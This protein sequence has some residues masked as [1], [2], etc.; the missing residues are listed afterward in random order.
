MITAVASIIGSAGSVAARLKSRASYEADRAATYDVWYQEALQGN[1]HSLDLL[2]ASAGLRGG[3]GIAPSTGSKDYAKNKLRALLDAGAITGPN[4]LPDGTPYVQYT[5]TNKAN[6]NA[7]SQP[8]NGPTQKPA[9][10]SINWLVV[11]V[12]VVGGFFAV[13]M[14]KHGG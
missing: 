5:V 2:T 14:L 6:S 1:Q 13:K 3:V 4:P 12:V 11:G 10:D 8:S 9:S 7:T